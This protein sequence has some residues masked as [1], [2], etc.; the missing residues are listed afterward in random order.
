[1]FFVSYKMPSKDPLIPYYNNTTK[2]NDVVFIHRVTSDGDEYFTK[3]TTSDV[4]QLINTHVASKHPGNFYNGN[5]R[6]LEGRGIVGTDSRSEICLSPSCFPYSTI[7]EFDSRTVQGGCTGTVISSKAVL[8]AAHCQYIHG[9]W[10]NL[11]YFAPGRFRSFNNP[12]TVPNSSGDVGTAREPYGTW[13]ADERFVFNA[14]QKDED[15]SY[16]ISVVTF[17]EQRFGRNYYALGEVTGSM[18]YAIT[19]NN[20]IEL[21]SATVTGYPYD[22]PDGTMWTSGPCQGGFRE[23]F[24]SQVTYHNCD[25]VR[26][27]DGAALL[28][29]E[30]EVVYGV[31][32]KEILVGMDYPDQAYVNLG[33]VLNEKNFPL[34]QAV[35]GM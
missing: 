11:E 3:V 28:D 15:M 30:A 27:M 8:T 14:W 31:Y 18:G 22:K 34:I 25:T 26:G 7:G 1:M 20:A 23:G 24:D 16:D 32:S 33:V 6:T 21:Q 10:T 17:K 4:N 9:D 13:I 12:P 19:T 29:L 2:Q 35:A 5:H